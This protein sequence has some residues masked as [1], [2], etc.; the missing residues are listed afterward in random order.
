M[1][2]TQ[3]TGCTFLKND[4]LVEWFQLPS[5]VPVR[6]LQVLLSP[7]ILDRLVESAQVIQEAL[8][9]IC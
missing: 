5:S 1:T 6:F 8:V 3:R 2:Q 9:R 7:G 4:L